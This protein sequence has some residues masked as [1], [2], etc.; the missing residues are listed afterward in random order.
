MNVIENVFPPFKPNEEHLQK[1]RIQTQISQILAKHLPQDATINSQID[2]LVLARSSHAKPPLHM[3]HHPSLCIIV[4]GAKDM[5]IA[6]KTYRYDQDSFLL[7]TQTLPAAGIILD[8]TEEKPYLGMLFRLD[9]QEVA[10]IA[11]AVQIEHSYKMSFGTKEQQQTSVFACEHSLELLE[12]IYRLV[13]LLDAPHDIEFM[14][15]VIKREIIYRLLRSSAG[16]ILAQMAIFDSHSNRI[17][18]VI[19]LI[20]Q[21]F[22]EPLTLADLANH[23]HMSISSLQH[24]FKAIT[25]ISPL[26]FQKQIRLHEA[27]RIMMTEFVDAATAGLRVGYNN[28]SQFS[29]EYRRLFGSPPSTDIKKL[30]NN[31]KAV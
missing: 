3:I 23:A 7:I 8:A 13:K 21:R 17:S 14:A 27:R 22:N 2:N 15:P 28:Q 5:I 18:K 4:Q 9:R 10:D 25:Q 12:A 26:Q 6:E 30:K 24:H 1:E 29:R 19:S 16:P 31:N 20:R 11:L